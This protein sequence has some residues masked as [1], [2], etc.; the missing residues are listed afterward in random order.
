[1]PVTYRILPRRG[2]VYVRFEGHARVAESFEA[3][4]RFAQD[5]L[6][7]PG[8][9][10]LIDLS[11]VTGFE[12]DYVALFRLH[13]QKTEMFVPQAAETVNVYIAP[14]EPAQ[15]LSHQ[16]LKSWQGIPGLVHRV[17][18]SETEALHILGLDARSIAALMAEE[19]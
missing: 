7:R 17:V 6:F 18:A 13:A 12:P 2:L 15:R 1:M 16:I 11:A 3:L 9:A 5:P 4:G 10:Q 8:L 19:V 14:T